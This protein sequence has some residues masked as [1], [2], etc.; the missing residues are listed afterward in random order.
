M[1]ITPIGKTAGGAANTGAIPSDRSIVVGEA[2]GTSTPATT[3]VLPNAAVQQASPAASSE[4][5]KQAV[6]DINKALQQQGRGLE[7]EIDPES[8]H[9]IIKVVDTETQQVIRQ[10]PTKDAL[11]IARAL[12]R[13]QSLLVHQKA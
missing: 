6:K 9:S 13:L 11:D 1:E 7:F 8:K 12:D 4:Q 5:V 3:T 2:S 10:M